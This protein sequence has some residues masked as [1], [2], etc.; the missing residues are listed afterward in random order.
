MARLDTGTVTVSGGAR[1]ITADLA[2]DAAVRA[3][4]KILS[5][6][7]TPR[8]TNAGDAMYFGRSNVLTTYGS[9]ILKGVSKAM[10]V[11]KGADAF[12]VFY[13]A[14]DSGGDQADWVVIFN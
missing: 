8:D 9:R 4:D 2:S 5:I 1:Q 6:E 13:M 3:S 10:N 14:S 11:E 12:S 7:I